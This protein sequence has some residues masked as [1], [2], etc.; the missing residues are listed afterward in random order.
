MKRTGPTNIW[1]RLLASKLNKYSNLYKARVWKR[2]AEELMG[3]TR[4][5]VEVNLSLINREAREGMTVVV[6]GS[7]LGA[8][9]IKKPVKVA[10]YRFSASAKKK[11]EEAGGK[12][13]TLEEL[14]EENP[15]GKGVI[16]LK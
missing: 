16:L 15:S 7:V 4:R 2:V 13:I 11:I 1:L 12:A 10:A 8:G 9:S 6:P 14:L 3:P 5:R